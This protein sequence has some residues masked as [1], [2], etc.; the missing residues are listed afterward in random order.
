[1][2]LNED[3][4]NRKDFIDKLYAF[5][6]H[7]GNQDGKGLTV[8]LNG[9]YGSGKTTVLDFIEQNNVDSKYNIIKYNAWENNFYPNPIMPILFSLKKIESTDQKFVAIFNE[10]FKAVPKILFNTVA[11][12]IGIGSCSEYKVDFFEEY[13]LYKNN[14]DKFKN[15]M[16]EYCKNKKTIF[17]VD[18]LDRCLPEYQIK[19]LEILHLLLDI[20]NLITLIA[21]DKQQL[22]NSIYNIFGNSNNT[23]GYLSKFVDYEIELPVGSIGEYVFPLFKIGKE[24][25]T[26]YL[27]RFMTE[28]LVDLNFTAREC[29]NI[30][31]ELNIVCGEEKDY[32]YWFVLFAFFV[33]LVKR[34]DSLIYNDF[35]TKSFKVSLNKR[36]IDIKDSNFYLFYKRIEGTKI[37]E[38]VDLLIKGDNYPN[39][40]VFLINYFDKID[41]LNKES[42]F[43][44]LNISESSMGNL[45]H[46]LYYSSFANI[47]ENISILKF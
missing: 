19:V 10:L 12:Q 42:L 27:K 15:I 18:E 30:I 16:K 31:S 47:I 29:Q 32:K 8:I 14:L 26:Q 45:S 6:D 39:F 46:E 33:L 24:I 11:T 21:I 23:F 9:K 40:I 41:N 20:P 3:R 5:F 7:Y 4:L 17:M 37:K 36:N 13:K 34:T 35:F 2:L 44:F 25:D 22:E 38:V 28:V 43:S 1:M